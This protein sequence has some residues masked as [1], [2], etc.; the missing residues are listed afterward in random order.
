MEFWNFILGEIIDYV[1]S[2]KKNILSF[3]FGSFREKGRKKK[4]DG[5]KDCEEQIEKV[6]RGL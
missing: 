6:G 2:F 5:E 4:A 3:R 1:H